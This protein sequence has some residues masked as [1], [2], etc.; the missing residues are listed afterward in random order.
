MQRNSRETTAAASKRNGIHV[1]PHREHRN[2]GP[3]SPRAPLRSVT[4]QKRPE[5]ATRGR[6]SRE[7]TAGASKCNRIRA[8]PSAQRQHRNATEFTRNHS[9]SVETKAP[10]HR[11]PRCG[12]QPKWP[13]QKRNSCETTAGASKPKPR[14]TA[15]AVA[16]GNL[17]VPEK[18]SEEATRGRNSRE[19]TAGA[20]KCKGIRARPQ[21]EHRNATE[22]TRNHSGSKPRLVSP[23]SSVAPQ[24][25]PEEATRGRISRET[26]GGASKR[27]GIR[28]KRE[29]RERNGIRAKPK[30]RERRNKGPS[31]RRAPLRSATNSFTLNGRTPFKGERRQRETKGDQSS[32]WMPGA[33]VAYAKFLRVSFQHFNE[34][35]AYFEFISFFSSRLLF[36]NLRLAGQERS[37]SIASAKIVPVI[38]ISSPI[39]VAEELLKLGSILIHEKK[40]NIQLLQQVAE[41]PRW[42]SKPINPISENPRTLPSQPFYHQQRLGKAGFAM[43]EVLMN[44]TL[45]QGN[46][47]RSLCGTNMRLSCVTSSLIR[48]SQLYSSQATVMELSRSHKHSIC[49]TPCNTLSSCK[50]GSTHSSLTG[51]LIPIAALRNPKLCSTFLQELRVRLRSPC[52]LSSGTGAHLTFTLTGNPMSLF[53]SIRG[54]PFFFEMPQL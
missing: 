19:T 49:G 46:A 40:A 8:L 44:T 47:F 23:A 28:A 22:F 37:E 13:P 42:A 11:A 41:A 20:S 12:R 21:R 53:R 31:H 6:N 36:K 26:T 16:V 48:M 9:G 38:H 51:R 30:Q 7:T 1:K 32:C 17:S 4:P 45:L 3:V 10:S 5:E 33:H 15:R 27:N 18:R 39:K 25:R 52:H 2:Q 54:L 14:P 34:F 50:S 29:H 43:L 24:K 35:L